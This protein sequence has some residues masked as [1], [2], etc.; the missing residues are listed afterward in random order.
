M[1]SRKTRLCKPAGHRARPWQGHGLI[2][3]AHR[4]SDRA[5]RA[6]R[7]ARDPGY[8]RGR[9]PHP[10]H[11]FQ[12]GV[13]RSQSQPSRAG[14]QCH[15]K[16]VTAPKASSELTGTS[17][18][19]RRSPAEARAAVDPRQSPRRLQASQDPDV[20]GTRPTCG[21]RAAG[22]GAP[23]DCADST[24][25]P[26]GP[27]PATSTRAPGA[28]SRSTPARSGP[29]QT[30]TTPPTVRPDDDDKQCAQRKSISRR[31]ASFVSTV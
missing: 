11:C 25:Q 15:R 18:A 1:G 12:G 21:S 13:A 10:I 16:R 19:A 14:R 20:A 28:R 24:V 31:T 9:A 5:Y 2:T 30:G 4:R 6:A 8:R 3:S 26:I 22:G 7:R 27:K 17:G 23:L 29:E